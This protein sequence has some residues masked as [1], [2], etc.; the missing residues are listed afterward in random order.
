MKAL[1]KF[2]KQGKKLVNGGIE[3]L[4]TEYIRLNLDK[5][6]QYNREQLMQGQTASGG[7]LPHYSERSV[8]EFG[9][10]RGAIRL[11]D[12]G[13]FHKSITAKLQ[14]RTININATDFKTKMLQDRY[15]KYGGILGVTDANKSDFAQGI[16]SHLIEEIPKQ[17]LK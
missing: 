2:L 7:S 16:K 11:K 9:K 14:A 5:L 1:D 4:A 6:E 12:T 13:D 10:P 15:D 8:R 3:R 17:L